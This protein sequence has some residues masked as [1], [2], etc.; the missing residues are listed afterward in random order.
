MKLSMNEAKLNGLW[1]RNCAI[2]QQV[3]FLKFAFGPEKFPGLS[4][5]EPLVFYW[6]LYNKYMYHTG[7]V[8]MQLPHGY[9]EPAQIQDAVSLVA[10]ALNTLLATGRSLTSPPASCRETAQWDS[11]KTLF[12]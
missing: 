12:E 3:L 2:I 6:W 11:G 10:T 7:M 8:G 5:N 4:R 9:D 1:A